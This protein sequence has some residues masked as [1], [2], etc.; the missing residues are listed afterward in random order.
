MPPGYEKKN[1]V[2]QLLR[3]LYG[4]KTSGH[5]WY[6]DFIQKLQ[7]LGLCRV[8]GVNCLLANDWLLILFYVDDI[9]ALY[10]SKHASKYDVFETELTSIYEVHILGDIDN[11]LGIRTLRNR[12][13][14]KLFLVLDRYIERIA[15]KFSIP[16][17]VTPP[18]TPLPLHIDFQPF[19]G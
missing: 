19:K 11:F 14:R 2:L 10:H 16:L 1:S 12:P 9:I 4:L 18:H 3:A 13:E 8:P 17:S 6:Q 7:K 15:D 5:L